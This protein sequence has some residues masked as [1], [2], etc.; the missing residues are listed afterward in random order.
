[1]SNTN[2]DVCPVEKAGGLD[3][4]IRRIL[5]NPKRILKKVLRP[6][7]TVLDYGCGPGFFTLAAA[8]MLSEKGKVIAADMQQGMLDIVKKKISESPAGEKI[9]LHRTEKSSTGLSEK[10]DLVIAFYVIHELPDRK[11]FFEEIKDL[12]TPDGRFFI[13]EPK[14]HVSERD[15]AKMLKDINDTGYAE[16]DRPKIRGSRAVL[17]EKAE[18]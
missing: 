3:N 9:I 18:R 17:L 6:D 8:E 5:Q 11:K 16:A 4:F 2:H 1:M 13:A 12:L 14:L 7:D 15:F 10:V